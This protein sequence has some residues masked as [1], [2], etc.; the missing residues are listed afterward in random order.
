MLLQKSHYTEMLIEANALD[1]I[2]LESWIFCH[3]MLFKSP[4]KWWGDHG[5]RDFPHEGI[6]LCLYRDHCGEIGRIDDKTRIPVLNDGVIRAIFKDYLGH[7]VVV[8]HDI[9]VIDT[10]GL[11]SF[12]AHTKPNADMDIGAKVKKGDILGTIA[13]TSHSKANILPHLHFSLWHPLKP[14]HYDGFIWNT[15]RNPEMI[16][17]L[18]PLP[19]IDWPYQ[20]FDAGDSICHEI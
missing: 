12:Y 16:T 9:S 19:V 4:D 6:D 7:A 14:I 3:G 15:I 5:R 10:A 18:D 13:D 2:G 11:I 20:A 17:L 8:E 1:H